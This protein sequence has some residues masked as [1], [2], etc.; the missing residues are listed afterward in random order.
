M[1][2]VQT[3]GSKHGGGGTTVQ[4]GAYST[5]AFSLVG[6]ALCGLLNLTHW[7]ELDQHELAWGAVGKKRFPDDMALFPTRGPCDAYPHMATQYNSPAP[8]ASFRSINR[9]SCLNTW[10]GGNIA[11]RPLDV[12]RFTH[13][14]FLGGA[15]G[16]IS[17]ASLTEMT[18][19]HPLTNAFAAWYLAY[20]MG[21]EAV[22]NGGHPTPMWLCEG[23]G[24]AFGHSGLDYGSGMD[25]AFY[26]PSFKLG[27][28]LGVAAV[29]STA[30]SSPS[31]MRS[32]ASAAAARRD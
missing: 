11:A 10:M 3:N 21:M 29:G 14:A 23:M 26:V 31:S 12:A 18:T 27:V 1:G 24:F 6:L 7:Y 32:T 4:R 8:N 2:G 9:H 25:M 13:A 30:A 17:D 20:G 15:G 22:W 5:N 19:L 16:L 28:A